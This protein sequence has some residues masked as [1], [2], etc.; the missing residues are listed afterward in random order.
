MFLKCGHPTYALVV[1]I[2]FVVSRDQAPRMGFTQL[3]Q[4]LKTNV[5]I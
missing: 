3:F 4:G 1:R 5:T 2:C